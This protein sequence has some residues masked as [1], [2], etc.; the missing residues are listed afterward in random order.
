MLLGKTQGVWLGNGGGVADGTIGEGGTGDGMGVNVWVGN[1]GG[2][3]VADGEGVVG[4]SV[5]MMAEGISV[6]SKFKAVG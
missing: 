2:V 4:I 3:I 5:G 1:I 6:G